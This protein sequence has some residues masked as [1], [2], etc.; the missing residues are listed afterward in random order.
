M[1]ARRCC[2]VAVL[3][4]LLAGGISRSARASEVF[5][6]EK[7]IKLLEAGLSWTVIKKKI[8]VSENFLNASA[9]EMVKIQDAAKK[10]G[11]LTPTDIDSLQLKILEV[12]SQQKDQIKNIVTKFI[13]AAVNSKPGEQEYDAAMRDVVRVGSAAIPELRPYLQSENELKRIAALH[14]YERINDKSVPVVQDCWMMLT[15]RIPAV[16]AQAAK[17]FAALADEKS[18]GNCIE[19]LQTPKTNLLDGY[20]LSLGYV[21]SKT[22][23]PVLVKTLSARE[24]GKEARF[25]A[26]FALGELGIKDDAAKTALLEAVLDESD[27]ALRAGAAQALGKLGIMEAL[28]HIKR[29]YDRF[30]KGREALVYELSNFRSRDTMEFL[31]YTCLDS[32]KNDVRISTVHALNKLT[33]EDYKNPE[34]WKIWWEANKETPEWVATGKSPSPKGP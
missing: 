31:I 5:D 27:D 8:E 13:N 6:N 24:N 33:G 9:D 21:R 10:A 26:A 34:D 14:A 30:G 1:V 16:R 15:D 17:A 25:A 22:A 7:L 28:A 11:A 4:L 32:D 20:A 3:A 2:C 12:A 23:L 18:I 19:A 29:A